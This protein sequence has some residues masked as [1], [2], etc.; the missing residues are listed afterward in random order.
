MQKQ[1]SK[2]LAFVQLPEFCNYLTSTNRKGEYKMDKTNETASCDVYRLEMVQND[3]DEGY[4]YVTEDSVYMQTDTA[5]ILAVIKTPDI[6]IRNGIGTILKGHNI[7]DYGSL[8]KEADINCVYKTLAY[9]SLY[10]SCKPEDAGISPEDITLTIVSS[11]YPE[12][13]TRQMDGLGMSLSK[14]GNG[15]YQYRRQDDF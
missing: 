12:E 10:K 11:K 5:G 1:F 4:R 9:A 15:I 13:L 8:Y 3:C 14:T 2:K 6:K 7:F